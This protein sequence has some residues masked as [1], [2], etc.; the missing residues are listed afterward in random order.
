MIYVYAFLALPLVPSHSP[1]SF[2]IPLIPTVTLLATLSYLAFS[3]LLLSYTLRHLF[4]NISQ[5][6][7]VFEVTPEIRA[8]VGGF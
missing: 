8:S 7:H 5:V 6:P 3:Q 2:L 1:P 4:K